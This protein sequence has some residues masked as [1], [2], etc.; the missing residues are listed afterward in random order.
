MEVEKESV[1]AIFEQTLNPAKPA[2]AEKAILPK[3][4][5]KKTSSAKNESEIISIEKK[6]KTTPSKEFVKE[7]AQKI[8]EDII[9]FKNEE[10]NNEELV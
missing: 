3:P 6:D 9:F 5:D 8:T 1:N 10:K 7:A 4:E 2:V